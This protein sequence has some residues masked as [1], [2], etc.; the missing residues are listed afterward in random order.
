MAWGAPGDWAHELHCVE[1][2]SGSRE[3]KLAEVGSPLAWRGETPKRLL[4]PRQHQA[5]HGSPSTP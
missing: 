1:Y 5:P 2:I 3:R 4:R